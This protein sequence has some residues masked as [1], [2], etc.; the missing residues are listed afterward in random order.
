VLV[1]SADRPD[2]AMPAA[3]WAAKSGDPVLWTGRDKLPPETA[4]AIKAHRKP[5]IYVLGPEDVISESVAGELRKLGGVKRI[6]GPDP[7]TNAIAFARF[8]DGDFGWGVTDP[9]HGLVFAT[10][11]RA[12]DAAAAAP[13]S[14]S[15]TYGPLLLVTEAQA[16]PQA[17]Q[18]YLLDIQP[19]YDK[20]PVRGVYNHGWL[21]GDEA[22][23]SADVQSRID[24]LLEIQPVDTGGD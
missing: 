13:L 23:I 18:D 16:L 5:K 3:A 9:G 24:T 15:G 12:L 8:T 2:F 22:A 6:S 10:T 14:A 7:V 19:G 21:M 1:A 17:L 20:D 11:A 4:A